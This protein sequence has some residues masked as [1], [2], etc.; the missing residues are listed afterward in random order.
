MVSPTKCLASDKER[1]AKPEEI[2]RQLW[3]K[4]L[5]EEYHYPK[6]RI[7]VAA[8]WFGSGISEKSRHRRLHKDGDNHT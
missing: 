6:E 2:V 4:K 1:P 8:V 3:I 7:Q 5:I